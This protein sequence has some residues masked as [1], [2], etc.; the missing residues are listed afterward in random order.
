VTCT[1]VRDLRSGRWTSVQSCSAF[2]NPRDV[3]CRMECLDA[4]NRAGDVEAAN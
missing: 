3:D 4:L 2:A 1:L